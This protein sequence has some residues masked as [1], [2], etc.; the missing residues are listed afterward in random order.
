M[1]KVDSGAAAGAAVKIA[2]G[3][4]GGGGEESRRNRTHKEEEENATQRRRF[5][6][7]S[8]TSTDGGGGEELEAVA[9]RNGIAEE[10]TKRVEKKWQL[11]KSRARGRRATLAAVGKHTTLL[12]LSFQTLKSVFFSFFWIIFGSDAGKSQ[13]RI[14]GI[15][16]FMFSKL[17]ILFFCHLEL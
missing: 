16:N 10:R 12:E 8:Q 14:L 2:A 1:E 9:A 11:Q 4:G 3:A 5:R 13:V 6:G 17:M 7:Q 15:L